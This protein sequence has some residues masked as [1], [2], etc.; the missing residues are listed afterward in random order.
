[1]SLNL[2]RSFGTDSSP[3]I[4]PWV[5]ACNVLISGHPQINIY[6]VYVTCHVTVITLLHK[7]SPTSYLCNT[8]TPVSITNKYKCF[9]ARLS[10]SHTASVWGQ[11][12][13]S[14]LISTRQS[15]FNA[16]FVMS[17]C[18]DADWSKFRKA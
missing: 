4:L 17:M 5:L 1:M 18:L 6:G 13:L 11:T 14:K 2:T 10:K 7:V 9:I 3:Q 15:L 12:G 8:A 16:N